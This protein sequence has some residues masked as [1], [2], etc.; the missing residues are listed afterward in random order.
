MEWNGFLFPCKDGSLT[1]CLPVYTVALGRNPRVRER[2]NVMKREGNDY[3]YMEG[4][5]RSNCAYG[6]AMLRNINYTA[7]ASNY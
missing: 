5:T 7:T 6:Y 3:N 4:P 2:H 1:F